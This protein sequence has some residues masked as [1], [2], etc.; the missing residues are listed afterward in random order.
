MKTERQKMLDGELY[1]PLNVALGDP[2]LAADRTRA[3]DLCQALNATL[4]AKTDEG[5]R[6]LGELSAPLESRCGCSRLSSA[7]TAPTSSWASGCQ[8]FPRPPS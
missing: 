7:T 5:R 8:T 2:E 6:L 4:E 3:H 1:A